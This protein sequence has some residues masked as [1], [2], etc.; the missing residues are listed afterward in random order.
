MLSLRKI[1]TLLRIVTEPT[2]TALT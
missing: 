1:L 2:K